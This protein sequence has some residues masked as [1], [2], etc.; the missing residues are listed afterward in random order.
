MTKLYTTINE[1]KKSLY[2]NKLNETHIVYD[3]GRRLPREIYFNGEL[4]TGKA[5]FINGFNGYE[6][7]KHDGLMCALIDNS[8]FNDNNEPNTILDKNGNKI[9]SKSRRGVILNYNN[10]TLVANNKNINEKISSNNKI[11]FM[12]ESPYK[13]GK[14]WT[15]TDIQRNELDEAYDGIVT[16]LGMTPGVNRYGVV[17]G[18]DATGEVTDA[19]MHPMELVF[20]VDEKTPELIEKITNVINDYLP[21][22]AKIGKVI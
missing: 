7:A 15:G 22:F 14:G 20:T 10:G 13:W 3:Q 16:E 5:S 21:S 17:I 8:L 11:K 19:Y 4:Y 9:I 6:S 12:L 2:K 1:F 18:E